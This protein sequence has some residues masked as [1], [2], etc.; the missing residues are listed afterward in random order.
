[1]RIG[2]LRFYLA[3]T[4]VDGWYPHFTHAR[5]LRVGAKWLIEWRRLWVWWEPIQR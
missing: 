3:R 5:S 2:P 1:M 4:P